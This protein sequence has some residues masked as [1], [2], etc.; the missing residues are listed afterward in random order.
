MKFN[1]QVSLVRR[2]MKKNKVR[3]FMTILATTMGCSFLIV[4]ASV[5]FGLQKSIT[6][7]ITSQQVITE[8]SVHGKEVDGEAKDP[9]DDEI[10]ELEETDGVK[11]VVRRN[12]IESPV[13]VKMNDRTGDVRPVITNMEEELKANLSLEKGE[14]PKAQNEIVVGY[15]FAK[16]L[17]TEEERTQLEKFYENPEGNVEEPKGFEGEVLG[18]SVSMKVTK[19]KENGE[20]E[21]EKTFDFKIVGVTEEPSKDWIED[22]NIYISDKYKQEILSAANA[23]NKEAPYTE[24]KAYADSLEKVEQVTNSLKDKGFVV[25]SITE[26]LDS[27]NLFFNVFKIG[28]IFVGTVAVLIASIGIFNTM[29]MA[30]T[31]RTQEIG[32]MKA[33]GA[34]P[35]VI[36]RIFLMES[37]FIGLIGSLLGVLI[38]YGVSILA[39]TVIPMILTA[40]AGTDGMPTDITFSDI[41]LSLVLIAAGISIGVA[42]V[43]GLRPAV[44]ATNVNVLSA[45]RREV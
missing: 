1:D 18:K 3:L 11:A 41:P 16:S 40:M 12:H 19:I 44:K 8:I 9:G 20:K 22:R 45:L 32:I 21:G 10:K 25:Y 17:L 13:E 29:T 14:V 7:E 15:S 31:E 38:S 30:V 42:V 4:L 6:D 27:V 34:Q 28:L 24:V 36:K 23:E 33:I 43:S 39:N 2:N 26:E 5:G 37:A 35:K